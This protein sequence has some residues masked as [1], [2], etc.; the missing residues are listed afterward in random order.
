MIVF[1]HSSNGLRITSPPSGSIASVFAFGACKSH[2]FGQIIKG[3]PITV[4]RNGE[5]DWQQ[6]NRALISKH[7]FEEDL[8]LDAQTDDV[9]S[10]SAARIERSGDI[11]FIKKKNQ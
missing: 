11:S 8:R 9:S 4:V 10:I 5:V 7:D 1:H 2:W 6:L 3:R